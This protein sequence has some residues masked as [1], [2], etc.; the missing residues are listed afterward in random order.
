MKK[1][2]KKGISII[3]L[4]ALI[5]T[6]VSISA[7][8]AKTENQS[9]AKTSSVESTTESKKEVLSVLKVP[10]KEEIVYK[11]VYIEKTIDEFNALGFEYGDSVN[12]M[13][14]NGF[15]LNDIP[16]YNGYYTKPGES[17]LV[18]YPG[19]EYID[20]CICYIFQ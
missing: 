12:I 18:A 9:A 2:K 20:A 3:C 16:Y 1:K 11:G 6:S 8:S 4:L 13:F 14:S 15:V 17:L 5:I 7:C 19:Y 10:V